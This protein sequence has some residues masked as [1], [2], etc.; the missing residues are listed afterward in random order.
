MKKIKL[1]S[2]TIRVLLVIAALLQASLW[3]YF[4]FVT[5]K[6]DYQTVSQ[7]ELSLIISTK[8]E[9]ME[10]A[11]QQIIEIDMN[12]Q[13]WL[14]TPGTLIYLILYAL[15]FLLFSQFYKGHIFSLQTA[16]FIR[17][18]GLCVVAWP[19]LLTLYP[20]V[21]ILCLKFTGALEHGEIAIGL[22]SNDLNK[23]ATGIM[24]MVVGW[25]MEEATKLK[26]DQE[27]T[28]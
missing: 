27:L 19:L 1:V 24:V 26:E 28:I 3:A 6:M 20:P 7:D 4:G 13:L 2:Q 5:E 15:L 11:A 16:T 9:G 18:I 23:L 12:P 17:R 10:S 14:T 25:V 22:S 21:L 8:F